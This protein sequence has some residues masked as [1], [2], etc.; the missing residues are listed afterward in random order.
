M[1]LDY[2]E[3]YHGSRR[4]YIVKKIYRL[5][6]MDTRDSKIDMIEVDVAYHNNSELFAEEIEED[7]HKSLKG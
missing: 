2:D 7:I 3:K 1:L 5:F 4:Y 6:E